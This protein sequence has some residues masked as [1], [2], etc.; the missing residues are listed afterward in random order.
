MWGGEPQGYFVDEDKLP[1]DPLPGAQAYWGVH[2]G[3]GYR[4]EVPANWNGSL[5]MWAHEFRGVNELELT[6]DNPPLREWLVANG[7]AWAASSY[8]ANNYDVTAGAKDTH[9]LTKF[10]DGVAGKPKRVYIAGASMGGHVTATMA[11]Q[12]PTAYDGALP[13]CGALGDYALYDYFLDFNLVAQALAGIEAQYPPGDEYLGVTVPLIKSKLELVPG[14]FPFTLNAQGQ[15]LAAATKYR[16]GGER[17]L[18]NQGFLFWNGVVPG[19]FLFGLG[20]RGDILTRVRGVPVDNADTVYQFDADPVLTPAEEL[21]ND[22]VLRVARDPQ[23][24]HP[25]GL[26]NVPPVN[27]N[28]KIPVLTLHT[29]GDL[30]MPISMEQIYA[31]RVAANGASDLLVQRAIRDVD[32]CAFTDEEIVTAFVELVTWV[33]TGVKPAGDNFLDPLAVADPAFGC[34]FTS[35]DRNYPLPLTIP[36]CSS[37][38]AHTANLSAGADGV[39]LPTIVR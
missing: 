36:P 33:E 3:A 1:F 35:S 32:H 7:Y 38:S 12:W 15:G 21:L 11:E 19:D 2:T 16:S 28:I 8:R 37:V 29:I 20:A 5:V 23:A 13:V 22:S 14:T 24:R 9:A 17:P 27:G 6:V 26:A 34:A 4:I 10:F 31:Q 25:N 18:F 30:Y 39:F